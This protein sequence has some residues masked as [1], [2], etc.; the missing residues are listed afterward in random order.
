MTMILL[1]ILRRLKVNVI[2]LLSNRGI[3]KNCL[4]LG[5]KLFIA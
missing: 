3:V 2:F 1:S 5:Y 4:F